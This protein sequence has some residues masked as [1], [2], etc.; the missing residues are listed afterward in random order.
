MNQYPGWKNFL[1]NYLATLAVMWAGIAL[2]AG[3]FRIRTFSGY[4]LMHIGDIMFPVTGDESLAALGI[5][6]TFA[7]IPYYILLPATVSKARVL[8]SWLAHWASRQNPRFGRGEKQAILV[9]ALKFFFL[10]MMVNWVIGNF[11]GFVHEARTLMA[12][13]TGFHLHLHLLALKLILIVDVVIFTFGYM[14]EVP[15]LNN[16]IKSVDPTVLGWAVC[17]AC[18]PPFNA[19][20][21]DLFPWQSSDSTH[22]ASPAL[23]IIA[24][25]LIFGLMAVFVWA[26]IALGWKASNLTNRGIIDDGPYR[27]SRHPAYTA[28]NLAWWIGAI[29][30]FAAGF[31]HSVGN[32]LWAMSCMTIATA[33]YAARAWTEER[34]LLM[35]DN[36]YHEYKA[37]VRWRFIPGVW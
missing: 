19:V 27:W 1:A 15:A 3:D 18:Y 13:S 12:A 16:V 5:I 31:S 2:C 26:S 11:G 32:G 8:F 7:L 10:P 24:N 33:F 34:H 25:G 4:F 29:P 21:L 37:R 30:S 23:E 22:F 28:K 36:G 14:V 20:M 6:Y 9:I 35:L 17:L